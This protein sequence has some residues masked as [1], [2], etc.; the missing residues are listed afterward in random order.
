MKNFSSNAFETISLLPV[1]PPLLARQK[2]LHDPSVIAGGFSD[3][4]VAGFDT[5]GAFDM[6]IRFAIREFI[7]N[8]Y[9][10][11]TRSNAITSGGKEKEVPKAFGICTTKGTRTYNGVLQ[12]VTIFHNNTHKLSE[13]IQTIEDD[14][15][16][17]YLVNYGP[18]ISNWM[19]LFKYGASDK[20]E[21]KGLVG[22]Y[23]EGSKR[24]ISY[25]LKKGY[26]VSY[27]C[28]VFYNSLHSE[29]RRYTCGT[30]E[31]KTDL[32]IYEDRINFYQWML[33]GDEHR[34]V[35]RIA[36][37]D[38]KFYNLIDP[39]DYL[40]CA[41]HHNSLRDPTD[42]TDPGQVYLDPF[43]RGNIYVNHFKVL[44]VQNKFALYGYD[45][46]NIDVPR[47]R[48]DLPIQ[49]RI[50][51]VGRVWS[52][53][54][55]NNN[56]RAL[57]FFD[58]VIMRRNYSGDD[59][60]IEWR[61]LPHLSEEAFKILQNILHQKYG[62]AVFCHYFDNALAKRVLDCKIMA[63][64]D[65]QMPFFKRCFRDFNYVYH[66]YKHTFLA[67]QDHKPPKD[68]I[69]NTIVDITKATIE[70]RYKFDTKSP[71]IFAQSSDRKIVWF[72]HQKV[73]TRYP[74]EESLLAFVVFRILFYLLPEDKDFRIRMIKELK[75]L[76]NKQQKKVLRLVIPSPKNVPKE[77]EAA[78]LPN[79]KRI[80]PPKPSF[81]DDYEV[82]DTRNYV[83]LRKKNKE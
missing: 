32:R 10:Q 35:V 17:V 76:G 21:T 69:Q 25:L 11:T 61:A 70:I 15:E 40:L 78:P 66:S 57:H 80:E 51:A 13:I 56:M 37:E 36:K 42:L 46:F 8:L 71:L 6:K 5:A 67:M 64:H 1:A 23:G 43:I 72:N 65:L 62:N 63:M 26:D 30:K 53:A 14:I 74:D 3:Q 48:T 59:M 27:E 45:I 33:P 2:N 7:Q 75:N 24:A 50:E 47:N 44:R 73:A 60:F 52:H 55:T 83:F 19:Q 16:V 41:S 28:P 34:L 39:C 49:Q 29:F 81:G 82:L 77:E 54:I 4:H 22:C 79:K 18:K 12:T 38:S 20:R 58:N 9:D 68:S 31:K